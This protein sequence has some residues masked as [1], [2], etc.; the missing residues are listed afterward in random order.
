GAL[1]LVNGARS[2]E[3]LAR[4]QAESNFRMALKAVDNYLTNV[5]ENRLLKEQQM[6]VA[7]AMAKQVNMALDNAQ[8]IQDLED[9]ATTDGLTRLYN[10]R[11]F[12]ER[13][14]S[15]FE[16]SR[17]YRRDLSVFLIDAD[18]FKLIN[19]SHGHEAGDRA[20][21]F[22]ASACREG[23]RQLDVIGRYGGEELVVLLPE[24]SAGL[25]YETAERLRQSIEQMQIPLPEGE[26]RLTVS[27]GVATAGPETETVAAL[28][29]QADRSLYE[30]KRNGRNQVVAAGT[31]R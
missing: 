18:H 10:R 9:L 29:N 11:Y 2:N 30:A 5:S 15:E 23:L 26:V 31:S 13:A 20:L 27:I 8:L 28:V 12:M 1:V 14:E 22:L 25:A 7:T 6:A 24:T 16:R 17:R 19:D 21:R 3:E 4:N